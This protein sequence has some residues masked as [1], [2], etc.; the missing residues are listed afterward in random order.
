LKNALV[1]LCRVTKILLQ[2]TDHLGLNLEALANKVGPCI[3]KCLKSV[4][5]LELKIRSTENP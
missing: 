5:A 4:T 2:N 3:L 1:F